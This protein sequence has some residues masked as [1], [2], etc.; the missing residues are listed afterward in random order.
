MCGICGLRRFGDTP[1]DRNTIDLL[2]V[3]NQNRGLEATGIALQQADGS[4]QVHKQDITPVSFVASRE[5]KEFMAKYFKDDTVTALGHTR[6][7]TKGSPRVNNNNHP[8]FAGTTAV[9]HNGVIHNDDSSFKDWKLERKAETD[10]DIFRAVFDEEGFTRKAVSMLSKLDGSGAFAAISEDHPGKLMIGRSG[11]PIELLGTPD[12]LMF[13]SEKGPL[14]KAIR[15]YKTIWG[16]E[17]RLMTPINYGMIAMNDDSAWLIGDKPTKGDKN[18]NSN[19]IEWHQE[20]RI[21][22]NYYAPSYQCHMQ[23]FGNRVKYYDDQPVDIVICP[24][25]RGYI[26]VPKARLNDLMKIK[27]KCGTRLG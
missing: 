12:F 18:C 6:K 3:N 27:C 7:V 8:L 9:V 17:M 24:G 4:I 25:C 26:E 15:P 16:I 23:Y 19:W 22:R 10:S 11:N 20:L 1:L 13:S 2:I 14:Y 21:A 5:Y